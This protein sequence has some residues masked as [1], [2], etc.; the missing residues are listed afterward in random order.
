[1]QT[2]SP[3]SQSR[4]LIWLRANWHRVLAHGTGLITLIWLAFDYVTQEDIFTFNRTVMLRTGS[5]GLLLLVASFACTPISRLFTGSVIQ[6]HARWV[7]RLPV[8]S[9]ACGICSVG[10]RAGLGTH[11]A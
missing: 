3:L 2:E 10:E 9:L 11:R 1:M 5:A 6:I 4:S 7:V 8:R